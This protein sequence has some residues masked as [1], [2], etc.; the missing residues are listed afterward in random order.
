M[1]LWQKLCKGANTILD[2]GANA[3]IYS[4]VAKAV[5][6]DARVYAFEPVERIFSHLKDNCALNGF[7]VVCEPFALSDH[8]GEAVIYDVLTENTYSVT[9]GKNLHGAGTE[10]V[11][12]KI[13]IVA[14]D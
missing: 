12:R 1:D 3:G 6:P 5:H 8:D 13:P 10:V 7:D 2:V 4:L 11:E 14:L 9:V